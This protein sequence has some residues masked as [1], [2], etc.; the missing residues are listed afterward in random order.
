[1]ENIDFG[2]IAVATLIVGILDLAII[3]LVRTETIL[4]AVERIKGLI[5]LDYKSRAKRSDDE[6]RITKKHELVARERVRT[7]FVTAETLGCK[8]VWNWSKELT[9]QEIRGYCLGHKDENLLNRPLGYQCNLPVE[10]YYL[11]PKPIDEPASDPSVFRSL[12]LYCSNNNP[13]IIHQRERAEF[14]F[15]KSVTNTQNANEL[16]SQ[17]ITKFIMTERDLRIAKEIKKLHRLFWR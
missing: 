15:L 7:N 8:W 6:I 1:M 17:I 11:I 5:R 4:K 13:E 14:Q 16:F 12:V 9:P 10:P 2:N 3:V